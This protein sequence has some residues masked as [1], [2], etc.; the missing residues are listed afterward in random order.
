MA[1]LGLPGRLGW[2]PLRVTIACCA[3]TPPQSADRV[4]WSL[5]LSTCVCFCC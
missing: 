4:E 3:T 1:R 2:Q 5:S